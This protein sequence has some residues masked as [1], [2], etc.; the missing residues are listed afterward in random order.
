MTEKRH[1]VPVKMQAK[2]Q[3]IVGMTDAF[4]RAH[5]N[6]EYAELCRKLA[7][8][9]SRKRPS[10]LEKGQAKSWAGGIVYTIGRVNFLFDTSQTPHL[11]A[12]ELCERFGVSQGTASGKSTQIMD[13]LDIMQ[14]HP[15]WTLPSLIDDNPLAW[16][17]SVDGL[18][19]DARHAPREVQ[20]EAYRLGLIPYLPE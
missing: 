5:L 1:S 11:S 8:T 6:E 10:P 20:E 7:A 13:M 12:K 17:I 9:L 4:C 15:E 18:I 3:A 14:F 19:I 2:Y 16:M